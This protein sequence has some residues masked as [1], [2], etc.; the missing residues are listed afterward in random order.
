[1]ARED[2]R[3]KG[4]RYLTEGRL[5]VGLVNGHC[6]EATCRGDSAEMYVLGHEPGGWHCSC[7]SLG[8]CSHLVALMLV[9]LTPGSEVR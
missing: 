7:P 3:A 9:T 4:I 6:I 1:M 2:A 8:R 5:V